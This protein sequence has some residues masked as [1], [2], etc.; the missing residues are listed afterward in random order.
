M[1]VPHFLGI[2][3]ERCGTGWIYN[4]LED[5]PQICLP[6]KEINFFAHEEKFAQGYDW[7]ASHFSRC[8]NR[9]S[10]EVSS[11][12][13][14][15][16]EAPERIARHNPAARIFASL[17]NP[18]ERALSGYKNS[19]ASGRIPRDTSFSE[20]I[21]A[22]P[23]ILERSRYAAGLQRFF[24]VFPEEHILVLVYE[25]GVLDPQGFISS[26]FRFL[27]VDPG[28]RPSLLTH[29]LNVGRRPRSVRLDW[30]LNRIGEAMRA[31]RMHRAIGW[32]KRAGLVERIRRA[33]SG[34]RNAGLTP[35]E[36]ERLR[37]VCTEEIELLARLT[38]AGVSR[39]LDDCH[40][41]SVP[42]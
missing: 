20:A 5:H 9:L 22:D 33:N 2:G 29:R 38:T 17:R 27:G 13:L 14:Y 4:C 1:T 7:Y 39:W 11:L 8:G 15:C 28:F 36:S 37:Q 3:G 24:D 21:H 42:S 18:V 25:D 41:G 6:Y 35:D 32:A 30:G 12:Y 19:I 34:S 23:T 31:C 10:G 16:P 26:I 40:Y